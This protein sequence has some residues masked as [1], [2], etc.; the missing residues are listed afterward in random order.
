MASG[1]A[2]PIRMVTANDADDGDYTTVLV[3][4][5][6]GKKVRVLGL[7]ATVLTTAGAFSLKSDSTVILAQ[8]LALGAP[9]VVP[10]TGFPLCETTSGAA[11]LA[12]NGTN[13]DSYC[14]VIY[15]MVDA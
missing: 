15:Q 14:T 5:V 3:A 2:S 4:A 8:H 6:T 11:L 13:V 10:P 1:D 12:N 9:L 7:I